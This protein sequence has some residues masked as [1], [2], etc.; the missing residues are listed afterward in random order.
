VIPVTVNGDV[1]M[2]EYAIQ[3]RDRPP[4]FTIH[5]E[6]ADERELLAYF[7]RQRRAIAVAMSMPDTMRA[8][9]KVKT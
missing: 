1:E 9:L 4:F 8:E 7:N 5:E 3:Y 6:F 2:Q